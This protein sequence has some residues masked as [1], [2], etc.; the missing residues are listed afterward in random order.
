MKKLLSCL[1]LAAMFLSLSLTGAWGGRAL[2][3]APADQAGAEDAVGVWI[4]IVDML[5]ALEEEDADLAKHLGSVFASVTL[6][7]LED[8]SYD[9]EVDTTSMI[10]AFR[11]GMVGYIEE[12]CEQFGLTVE[13]FEQLNGK[14]VSE[15][16][17]ESIAQMEAQ[18][19][20]LHETGT[21]VQEGSEIT[22]DGTDSCTFT[23]DSLLIELEGYGS[24]ELTRAGTVGLWTAVVRLGDVEGSEE[25]PAALQDVT[26]NRILELRSDESFILSMDLESFYRSYRNAVKVTFLESLEESGVT[27]ADVE[28]VYGKPLEEVVDELIAKTDLSPLE[29]VLTGSYTEKEGEL[30]GTGD[31]GTRLEGSWSRNKMTLKIEEYATLQFT[32]LSTEDVLAKGEGAMSYEEYAAA[33]MDTEVVIEAYVQAHQDWWQDKVTVYARDADGAY[34]LYEMACSE[35]D[36]AL[37]IPGQKIR[38]SG[39]KSEWSGEVEIVDASFEIVRG[40]YLFNPVDLTE[41]LGEEELIDYQ[42]Q[43]VSF[44]GLTIE[45]YDDT[46]AAFAYKDSDGKT[47]D[48]YFKASKDGK[49]Y[50][51]CV[52]FYLCGKD[53]DVYKAVE[54]LQVGD[55]VDLE[56]FLYWYNGANPHVTAIIVK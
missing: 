33:E 36:A 44:R 5:P 31:D 29:Q 3:E 45:A 27:A 13:E 47:D 7:L 1:L 8:G 25:L 30:T 28:T 18:D 52:E 50:D 49:T 48:L 6:E 26:F 14:T 32:H 10:P 24:V 20:V 46:G 42:N 43:L 4:G 19:L 38:V 11:V 54:A 12:V 9:L 56:A 2:A 55:V 37:L 21:Y 39:V 22:F 23:G 35:E 15:T 34:F 53:T 41:L 40:S 17:E 51:F 16:I